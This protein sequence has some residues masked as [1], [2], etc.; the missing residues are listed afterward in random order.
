MLKIKVNAGLCNRL[1]A[2]LSYRQYAMSQQETLHVYWP[3]NKYCTQHFLDIFELM[4]DVEFIERG[5][6]VVNNKHDQ[7][8]KLDT[9]VL[10]PQKYVLRRMHEIQNDI[11]TYHAIHVRRTDHL[12]LLTTLGKEP[13]SDAQFFSFIDECE[14]PVYLATDS[15]ATR[16]AYLNRYGN[17]IFCNESAMFSHRL[18][19][20][21]LFDTVIDMFMCVDAHV[22]VGSYFSSFSRFIEE[23]QRNI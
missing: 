20:T 11:G 16:L 22:F 1:R 9:S 18:R 13:T 2:L 14:H 7:H 23:C 10:Q 12:K 3:I 8:R 5:G 21:S 19:E 17:R 4:P 6:V 15:H